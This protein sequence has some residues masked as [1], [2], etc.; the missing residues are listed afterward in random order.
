VLLCWSAVNNIVN[1][2]GTIVTNI[3]SGSLNMPPGDVFEQTEEGVKIDSKPSWLTPMWTRQ[4]FQAWPNHG[5]NPCVSCPDSVFV[6]CL[7]LYSSL[8]FFY[9]YL[10]YKLFLKCRTFWET[11]NFSPM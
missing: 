1:N 9:S 4:A 6:L 3:D 7:V 10:W 8:H 11:N 2:H 5:K